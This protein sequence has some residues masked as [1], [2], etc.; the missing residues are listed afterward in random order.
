MASTSFGLGTEGHVPS[1]LYC[2]GDLKD[3]RLE[4]PELSNSIW[5]V[6]ISGMYHALME[7]YREH[8]VVYFISI[9]IL[10]SARGLTLTTAII[11]ECT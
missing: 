10:Q 11:H 1:G 2:I 5:S 4:I 7:V 9:K 6:S 3:I 8:A